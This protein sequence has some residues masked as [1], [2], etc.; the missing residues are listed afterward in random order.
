MQTR[1]LDPNRELTINLYRAADED[2]Q[3]QDVFRQV[4]EID[5]KALLMRQN[6]ITDDVWIIMSDF[7]RHKVTHAAMG[8]GLLGLL[9][10]WLKRREGRG[11]EIERPGLKVKAR[12]IREIEKTLIALKAYDA[13]NITVNN[14]SKKA[15]RAAAARVRKESPFK[16]LESRKTLDLQS[17]IKDAQNPDRSSRTVWIMKDSV[18]IPLNPKIRKRKPETGDVI[19]QA[20]AVISYLEKQARSKSLPTASRRG[21]NTKGRK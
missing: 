16:F 13:L 4:K 18:L 5:A 6:P 2:N 14:G 8:A 10:A 15:A 20:E 11:I 17:I 3:G 9:A 12:T 1:R 19:V 7:V 21:K